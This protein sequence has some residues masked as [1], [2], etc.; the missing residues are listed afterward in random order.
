MREICLGKNLSHLY[1]DSKLNAN[2]KR[3]KLVKE[4]QR[5]ILHLFMCND[6]KIH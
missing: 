4:K 1:V 6:F 5:D 3:R 2:L